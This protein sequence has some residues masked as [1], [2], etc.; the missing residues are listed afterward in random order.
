MNGQ[1]GRAGGWTER[2]QISGLHVRC[3]VA[4][5]RVSFRGP[6]ERCSCTALPHPPLH[7]APCRLFSSSTGELRA[8]QL[9]PTLDDTV[10]AACMVNSRC[11]S[12]TVSPA[13][14]CTGCTGWLGSPPAWSTAAASA[15]RWVPLLGGRVGGWRPRWMKT[16]WV[17]C[18]VNCHCFSDTVGWGCAC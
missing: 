8:L 4:A 16:G 5:G 11:F 15:T 14:C 2:E 6:S 3:L 7:P 12:D 18:M 17:A 1:R 10:W 13:G 9:A